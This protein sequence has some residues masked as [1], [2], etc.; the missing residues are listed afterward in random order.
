MAQD[1][2]KPVEAAPEALVK[3]VAPEPVAPAPVAEAPAP[4]PAETAVVET[5]TPAPA[6][7]PVAAKP[8]P[9]KPQPSVRKPAP[10]APAPAPVAVKAAKPAPARRKAS[11][12]KAPAPAREVKPVPARAAKKIAA[13]PAS[14]APA[15][16]VAKPRANP[17]SRNAS[18]MTGSAAKPALPSF[19]EKT[20]AKTIPTDFVAQFQTYF[21]DF[22]SKAKSAYEKGTA[23]FGEANDFAKGN[24]EALVESGKILASGLQ[25][26]GT[27][28][29][30]D[31][32]SA[33]ETMTAE[34]KELAAAKTPAEFLS[35]Q[36]T[37]LR[38]NFDVAVASASKNT[39]AMLKLVNDVVTPI[40]GRVTLAVEKVKAA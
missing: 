5:V 12:A 29:V 17:A 35:L 2:E 23:A 14:V 15:K 1:V 20:M 30:T 28:L 10:A 40:S 36:S 24:V 9:S 26:M 37:L 3:T 34:V 16:V 7:A 8:L 13:R 19:K 11:P 38:K 32:R 18:A 21:G 6:E 27:G 22:Q 25:E 31:S 33:F 39:E 4:A